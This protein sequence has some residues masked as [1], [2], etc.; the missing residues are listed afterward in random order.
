MTTWGDQ[1]LRLR[2]APS[3]TGSLHVGGART[4]LFNY[5]LAKRSGGSFILRIEDTDASRNRRESEAAVLDDL[6]W[7][8]LS[9]DEGPDVGG[10]YGPYR[11]SER[12]ELYAAAAAELLARGA[13]YEC[14][15]SADE[16]AREQSEQK[17]AGIIAT[18]YQGRCATL[19]VEQRA[20]LRAEGRNPALR[21]RI[22]PG[23]TVVSDLVHGPVTFEHAILGDFVVVRS[24]GVPTYNFA[25][26]F[27][28]AQM[29]IDV[30]VRGDEHLSNT[31]LQLLVLQALGLPA[32]RYAHVPLILNEDHQKLSKRHQT[33][34]VAEYRKEGYLASALRDHLALLGWSPGDER[35]HFTLAELTSEFSLE[36]VGR[37]ASVYNAARLRAFNARALRSLAPDELR[38]LIA[39]WLREAGYHRFAEGPALE[40]FVEAYGA[41][42]TTL[43]E[44]VGFARRLDE[45]PEATPELRQRLSDPL[46]RSY[47]LA[48][49]EGA[50]ADPA[51]FVREP[52]VLVAPSAKQVGL[53][54]KLAYEALRLAVSG[55]A[56]GA[57]LK[58]VLDLVGEE[59]V[60]ERLRVATHLTPA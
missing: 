18:R 11:Q 50:Q 33:V 51:A 20:T 7:L 54:P 25:A 58:L 3:P 40:R 10:P 42:I 22:P 29:A 26:A 49:L 45:M 39:Q 44:V 56:H 27:D 24:T 41:E 55:T 4:A 37:S 8:G 2:F 38:G 9:W 52:K 12:A 13:V 28:D 15:C 60:L 43:G 34:G 31:P 57:P 19:S 5:L 35:E 32:P 59:Q 1:P 6:H 14:F 53:A 23:Q 21:F 46:V 30:V 48:L 47:L 16:L 36:R 17:A